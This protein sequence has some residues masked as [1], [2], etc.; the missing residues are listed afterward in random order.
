MDCDDYGG[1]GG[2]QAENN[3]GY[4]MDVF[5]LFVKERLVVYSIINKR[6]IPDQIIVTL[7]FL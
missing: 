1:F 7:Q 5:L 2:R 3:Y 6:F 4:I